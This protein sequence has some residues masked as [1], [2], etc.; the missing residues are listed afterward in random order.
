MLLTGANPS[1][2]WF[3]CKDIMVQG[4][5]C[6]YKL[7]TFA[8]TGSAPQVWSNENSF[9]RCNSQH[10]KA[11]FQTGATVAT[12][13]LWS[14]HWKDCGWQTTGAGVGADLTQDDMFDVDVFGTTLAICRDWHIED[15]VMWDPF[16]NVTKFFKAS[17]NCRVF[18]RGG[19][20]APSGA[21]GPLGDQWMGGAGFDATNGRWNT[22][23]YVERISPTAE[24]RGVQIA[25]GTGAQTVFNIPHRLLAT[26]KLFNAFARSAAANA[27]YTQTAD[28]TNIILTYSAA[29]ASGTNNL[30]WQWNAREYV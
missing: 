24:Q 13:Q 21:S 17:T 6:A 11:F 7:A 25:S 12:D 26:P 19:G 5:A 27:A 1:I 8:P 2:S 29:P 14:W 9:F 18:L 20:A 30:T 16:N 10:S 28:A 3:N 4:F 23:A 15:C 22:G